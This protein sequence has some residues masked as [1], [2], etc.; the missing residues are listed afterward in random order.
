MKFK[1]GKIV[2][3]ASALLFASAVHAADGKVNFTGEI[4]A[5]SC[6][7][8][9]TSGS[10]VD[11][12]LGKINK[13]ALSTVGSTA[14]ATSFSIGLSSCD[15]SVKSAQVHFDGTADGNN[16]SLLKVNGTAKGV[17]IGLYESDG[18]TAINLFAKTKALDIA[19]GKGTFNFVAKYVATSSTV[20]VG[21]AN[22]SATFTISYQ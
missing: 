11:V 8:T 16:N 21:D 5:A 9:G 17:A 3:I 10:D 7:V 12:V 1:N 18:S 22:A 20:N 19:S 6:T 15:S 14:A 2:I 4:I 13:S